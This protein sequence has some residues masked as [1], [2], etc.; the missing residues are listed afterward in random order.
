MLK[1][2]LIDVGR[3]GGIADVLGVISSK[4]SENV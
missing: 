2:T 3:Q 1:M 4:E